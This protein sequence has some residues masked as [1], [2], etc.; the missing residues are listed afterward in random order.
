MNFRS[1]CFYPFYPVYTL[2]SCVF[3]RKVI[4]V[5]IVAFQWLLLDSEIEPNLLSIVDYSFELWII[6]MPD[7]FPISSHT[8]LVWAS[9]LLMMW[10]PETWTSCSQPHCDQSI[11]SPLDVSNLAHCHL[12]VHSDT[13]SSC[14]HLCVY[15]HFSPPH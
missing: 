6:P 10:F 5:S 1:S 8:R 4:L 13:R 14:L 11:R 7:L 3:C 12:C 9:V 2:I 15:V